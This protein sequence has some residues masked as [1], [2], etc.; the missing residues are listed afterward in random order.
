MTAIANTRT[1]PPR[2]AA[3]DAGPLSTAVR[4]DAVTRRF[5]Q[6]TALDGVDLTIRA[7]ETVALLGPNGAGKSTAIGLMLGLLEPTAGTVTILGQAPRAAVAAGRIGSMLQDAGLPTN[8]RVGELISF[9]RR[10]YPNPLGVDAILRRAGL[11]ELADRPVDR[12]SGGEGQRLR[13]AIAIAGDPDL[14]FLDEPTVAMDVETRRAFWA[15]MRR[16]AAEGRTI[17]FATHYLEEADQVADRVI[18][19]DHGRV[20][21][22]G[23]G[24]S[25]RSRIAGRT[26]S[27]DTPM[28]EAASL[29]GLP[30]V[31]DVDIRGDAVRLS[32]TDADA[33]V[34][35]LF[36]SDM[37]IHDLEVTGADLEDAFIALTT[38]PAL[39]EEANR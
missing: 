29:A 38:D 27:F 36:A 4:F 20:V 31:T 19:L 24:R 32:T 15:D 12:L 14:V 26:V 6:V 18:V 37:T 22:D 5:G 16:S 30:G 1:T 39:P 17:L 9:A 7:G 11:G 13:F 10:L 33:T 35:A 3:A 21:A 28:A 34:R 8:V 25:L 2:P 23:T